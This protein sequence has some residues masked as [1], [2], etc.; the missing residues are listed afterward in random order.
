MGLLRVGGSGLASRSIR[1]GA[2][3]RVTVHATL[4]R[5]GRAALRRRHGRR[6]T[7]TITVLLRTAGGS[8]LKAQTTL[9]A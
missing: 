2:A 8:S 6:A 9:P 4:T 5:A 7:V 1:L 3:G